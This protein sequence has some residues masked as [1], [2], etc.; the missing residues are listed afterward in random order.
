MNK[1][2]ASKEQYN[3]AVEKLEEVLNQETS[4]IIRDS[5]IKRFEFTFDLA[6]KTIKSF[7]EEDKGLKCFSPKDCFRQAYQAGL[8]DYDESWLE[9]TDLRNRAVHTYSQEFS[10]RLFEE[11]PEI[12]KKFKDLKNK[13]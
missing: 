7:L 13:I 2:E 4:E 10:K 8:I 9:M 11:L 1:L 12:L 5:A 3:K 6:W